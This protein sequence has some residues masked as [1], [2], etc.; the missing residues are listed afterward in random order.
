M[1]LN[2]LKKLPPATT[3]SGNYKLLL[4]CSILIQSISN[5]LLISDSNIG[6]IFKVPLNG[7]NWG[8]KFASHLI[9][10][11]YAQSSRLNLRAK[12]RFQKVWFVDKL[13]LTV[14]SFN[15][16]FLGVTNL[17]KVSLELNRLV[18]FKDYSANEI[19]IDLRRGMTKFWFE[20]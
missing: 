19:R 9:W 11:I 10:Y 18:F 8:C 1:T 13:D 14:V 6:E 7:M 3:I 15:F 2:I 5:S 17:Q 12:P 16:N 4:W 20:N